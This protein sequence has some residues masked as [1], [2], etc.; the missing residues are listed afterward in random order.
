MIA[1]FLSIWVRDST[2]TQRDKNIRWFANRLSW[3]Q[4]VNKVTIGVS[5]DSISD[6]RVRTANSKVWDRKRGTPKCSVDYF[7]QVPI[8]LSFDVVSYCDLRPL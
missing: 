5:L 3:K 4:L 7:A 2:E 8:N 6:R 1:T